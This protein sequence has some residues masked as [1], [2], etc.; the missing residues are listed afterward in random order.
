[1][2]IKPTLQYGN[3]GSAKLSSMS[4]VTQPGR[5]KP[6]P[7]VK[8][9][10]HTLFGGTSCCSTRCIRATSQCKICRHS[11]SNITNAFK[12]VKEYA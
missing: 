11:S 5:E 3:W 1:M 4:Q 10:K 7:H 9:L 12:H 8:T 2:I 6:S